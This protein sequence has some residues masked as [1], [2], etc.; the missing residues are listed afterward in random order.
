MATKIAAQFGEQDLI[1]RKVF[2]MIQP[3]TNEIVKD[4]FVMAEKTNTKWVMEEHS[5]LIIFK[6]V[7]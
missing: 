6:K 2:M 7:F 5:N 3:V 1:D 4:F